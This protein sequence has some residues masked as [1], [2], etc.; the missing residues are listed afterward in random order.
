MSRR[1]DLRHAC[2]CL[3]IALVAAPLLLDAQTQSGAP[4]TGSASA[5]AGVA[6]QPK[7]ITLDDYPRFKRIAGA[8][9]SADGKWLLYTVTPNEGDGVLYV[10]SLDTSTVHEIP[11]GTGGAFSDNGRWVGYFIAPPTGRGGRGAAAGR[12]GGGRGDTP[13]PEGGA[14]ATPAAR[15]F[16]LLDLQTGAKVSLPSV[17]SFTFSPDGEWAMIRPQTAGATPPAAEAGGRGGGRGGG[18]AAPADNANTPGTDLLMR[19]LATGAQRYV[20]N[21]GTFA[22]DDA[23][24]LMAYTVRGQ[25]RLGNGVYLMTVGSG[26]QRMLDAATADYD[27]LTWSAEGTNLAVLRGDKARGKLQKDNVLL[28]WRN[29]GSPSG[30]VAQGGATVEAK[31]IDPAKTAGLPAGMVIS[32]FSGLRWSADGQRL[33]LGLKAQEP[34]VLP[35]TEPQANVDV[36]HWKDTEPQSVQIL[37]VAQDRRATFA[38]VLDLA[39]GSIRRIADD[40]MR[41]ITANDD[42]TWAIGRLDAPYRGQISWGG[43]KADIYRVSMTTGERTLVEPGLSRTMGFSPDGK[44][45]LYLKSGRVYSYEVASGRKTVIDGGRSFVDAED[46]HDYEKPVYG[47]A[48]FTA[49]GKSAILYDRFD[50][51]SLPLA[52]GQPVNLTKGD[53][54]RQEIVY[55]YT[56]LVPPGRPGE[57]A[58]QAIDLTKPI[59]LS[60]TGEYTKKRGYFELAP[61]GTPKP[62]VWA[63]KNIGAPI[64]A[65]T[66]DRMIYTQ[67]SFNQYPNY[68]L[69]DKRF[70]APR[71]ITDA[72]PEIFT[73][74]AWGTKKLIDYKN[75]K[76]QRLQA[77]LTLPAGYEPGKKYPMLVYFY[78][79]MSNTHHAFSMPT[80][81]D[82]PHISTYASNGYLVLQPDVV[83]EIGKPGSSAL[84]CV[85][86][87]VKKVIE[88]GYADAARVGLQGHSWGGYQSSFIV[89]QT[90]MFA[91]VV[92]G[93]P[94]T[95]LTSFY[96]TLYRSSGNIQQGITEVGQVRMGDGVTPWSDHALYESQSPIHNA[97]NIK[98]P[99]LIL[100]GTADGAVDWGQGLEFYAAARRLGKQVI[101]LSYP[102][103]AHHLGRRENQKDFQVRMRQ[104]FDHYLK[105]SP[106]PQWMTEGV[107][108][109]KKGTR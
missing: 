85:G 96:G 71:Q 34:E 74:F 106:A 41:T 7:P 76:G 18:G 80:Y 12:G 89:T 38:A 81:D 39:S 65:R 94:P 51:W 10:K 107:P 67:S 9:L 86:S 55:R 105:G 43:N 61:G 73:E 20:G 87:A 45:F 24:K 59:T 63:D 57:A 49:D 68:W 17:A 72:M 69:S 36:W 35:T 21:V 2:F 50:L 54:A 40:G 37:R 44:W 13:Q 99:F 101:M 3:L 5:A 90:D 19:H 28:I 83:Y 8:S 22:F 62:L 64:L 104:F 92:T 75:S 70:G 31:T 77:T 97:P 23:G 11:R 93:A 98:T 33:Q 58:T 52:G 30:A 78:E 26:E 4:G 108:Q 1:A 66:A 29:L 32:E 91:A 103:E 47:V 6:G 42:L 25:Q 16:E 14:G 95:D 88:L 102:E 46:D 79:I 60:A 15:A 48:G 27:Q 82:R 100:H 56:R 84:D 109:V 53:G